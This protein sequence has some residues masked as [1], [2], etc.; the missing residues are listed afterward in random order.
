[1]KC[2]SLCMDRK[3]KTHPNRLHPTDT[4]MFKNL[5]SCNGSK[6]NATALN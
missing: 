1:V 6:M 4:E 3:E 2:F 5:K